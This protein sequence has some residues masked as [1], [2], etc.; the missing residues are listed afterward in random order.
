MS[1][2]SLCQSLNHLTLNLSQLPLNLSS[3]STAHAHARTSPAPERCCG[4][5]TTTASAITIAPP[6]AALPPV[7]PAAVHHAYPRP[8]LLQWRS[9]LRWPPH[10]LNFFAPGDPLSRSRSPRTPPFQPC[11]TPT[12]AHAVQRTR[13][14]LQAAEK[15]ASWEKRSDA[16]AK[17]LSLGLAGRSPRA[18][19]NHGGDC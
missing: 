17:Q 11:P 10:P 2:S 7:H 9:S 12:Q 6:P 19:V 14:G 16:G 15:R 3:P 18:R 1:Q 13:H 8:H 4:S 5:C